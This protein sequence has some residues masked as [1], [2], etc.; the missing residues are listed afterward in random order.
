VTWAFTGDPWQKRLSGLPFALTKSRLA[1]APAA[2][3][4]ALLCR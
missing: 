2:V 4:V 1:V 3:D